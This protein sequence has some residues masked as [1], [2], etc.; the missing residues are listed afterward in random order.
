MWMLDVFCC[1][2]GCVTLLWLLNTR[3]AADQARRAGSALEILHQTETELNARKAE[4]L[5]TRADLDQTRRK[6][7]ADIEDLQGRLLAMTSERDETAKKLALTQGDL[8]ESQSKL[9]AAANRSKELDD[10]LT[11]KQKEAKDLS[12]RLATATVSADELAKLLRQR[13]RER[14]ALAMKAKA[15]EDQLHDTDAKLRSVAKEAKDATADLAAMRKTGDELAAARSTIKDLQKKVDDSNA[16]LIDLQGQKAK[17]ADKYDKLR[18]DSESRFAGIAMT[19]RRVVFLV[20][21]S[22]SMKEVANGQPDA[23]KW[24]TVVETVARVM[25][26]LP[27][28]EQFQVVT[29]SRKAEYLFGSGEWQPYQGEAS[30]KRVTDALRRVEPSGDT[31]LY[32][33]LD[34]A[35]RLRRDGLDTVYVF[36]D[37]LP[38]SGPG[39]TS[40]QERT[41]R[42]SDRSDRLGRHIRL[43]LN[44]AWNR[45][46]GGRKVRINAIGFF[47]ESPEL[48]SFLWTLSRENEGSFVGMSRP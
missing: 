15:A 41:L 45:A 2:L 13:E 16:T 43:T 24:P 46:V 14:D 1:A 31:N 28:L 23:N 3:E 38:T 20:D 18:I 37:G 40:E 32:D 47:Y 6:L 22:G 11:R 21:T 8:T 19:G 39:L 10:L 7:N 48:G 44:A 17:L 5:A 34:L 29:F 33:G 30:A 12:T 4:L 25:R 36:S 26:S 27:D 35:F 42:E 9:A